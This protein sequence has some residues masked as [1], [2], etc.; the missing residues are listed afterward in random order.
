MRGVRRQGQR[1]ALRRS[2]LRWLSWF[3]QTQHPTQPRVRLQGEW[4]LRRGRDA[5]QPVPSLPL[6]EM[7]GGEDESR[8]W[9]QFRTGSAY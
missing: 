9:V 5:T 8:R 1:E 4:K 3:L 2:Q 7:L 6:Q